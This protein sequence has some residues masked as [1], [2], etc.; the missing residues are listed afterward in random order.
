MK[1]TLVAASAAMTLAFG[2]AGAAQAQ[3]TLK[4]IKD[5]GS[6]TMGVR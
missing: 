2:L 1:K 4:K 5:S 3:D 6:I